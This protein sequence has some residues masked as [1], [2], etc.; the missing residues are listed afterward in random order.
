MSPIIRGLFDMDRCK[1]C[2]YAVREEP[3][4]SNKKC[5][6]CLKNNAIDTLDKFVKRFVEKEE[7]DG[8][9]E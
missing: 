7:S 3:N 6:K 5:V 2:V 1:G 9:N 8:K 4:L